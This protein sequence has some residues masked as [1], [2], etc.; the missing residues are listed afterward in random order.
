MASVF[1]RGQKRWYARIKVGADWRTVCLPVTWSGS[2]AVRKDKALH[3]ALET[4]VTANKL[5]GTDI[6]EVE[7]STFMSK[8]V[9]IAKGGNIATVS[10]Q[11]FTDDWLQRT[12][13][14]VSAKTQITRKKSVSLF[15][16][17]VGEERKAR[18]IAYSFNYKTAQEFTA[19]LQ[20][21][22]YARSSISSTLT[23]LA[24]CADAAIREHKLT[25]NPFKK[26]DFT[27]VA[28]KMRL[29]FSEEQADSI[30][31]NSTG[32]VHVLFSLM[33]MTGM[34][35]GDALSLDW[36]NINPVQ[37][38][39][40]F[41]PQ[42]QRKGRERPLAIPIPP[43]LERVLQAARQDR[44]ARGIFDSHV[45]PTLFSYSRTSVTRTINL[46]I[47]AA[48]IENPEDDGTTN[49]TAHCCRH[50]YVSMLAHAGI[51]EE[52][53]MRL[54][55]HSGGKNP[56]HNAYTHMSPKMLG[57]EISKVTWLS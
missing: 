20:K 41:M 27:G 42:K 43:K 33:L 25:V 55:G 56:V 17:F 15:L 57:K 51:A 10:L 12:A 9:A 54:V 8:I 6:S 44:A 35:L 11:K 53:R 30:L 34:R 26:L 3:V 32:E 49:M 22:Q 19:H 1:K 45:V 29:A 13:E 46:T 50:F 2:D 36:M 37:G 5:S 31:K 39:I 18:P 52:V 23:Y 4:E 47:K 40:T 7:A 28:S 48:G 24:K 21:E 38:T 16:D 14:N